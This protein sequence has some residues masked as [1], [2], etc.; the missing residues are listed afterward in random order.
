VR[1]SLSRLTTPEEIDEVILA[2]AGIVPSVREAA[3]APA[4]TQG[5]LR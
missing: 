4:P 2:V 3:A 5:A 1:F